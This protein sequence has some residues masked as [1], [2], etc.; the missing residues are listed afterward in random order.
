L[1]LVSGAVVGVGVEIEPEVVVVFD[2]CLPVSV[3][4]FD[5]LCSQL[6]LSD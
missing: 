2:E 1:L 5:S 6:S 3:G 4:P